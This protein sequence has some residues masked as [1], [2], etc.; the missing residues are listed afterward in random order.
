MV[1]KMP[2]GCVSATDC[3]FICT[4]MVDHRGA[5]D[6]AADLETLEDVDGAVRRLAADTITT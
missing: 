5:K 4:K 3:D 6:E 1:V 2:D